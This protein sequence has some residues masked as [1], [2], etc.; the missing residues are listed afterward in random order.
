MD[1]LEGAVDNHTR[2]VEHS[3]Q[4]PQGF[5]PIPDLEFWPGAPARKP[6]PT[7][8]RLRARDKHTAHGRPLIRPFAPLRFRERQHAHTHLAYM[9]SHATQRGRWE[10]KECCV[11]IRSWLCPGQD[12]LK[13]RI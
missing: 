6:Y 1:K 8:Q 2:L 10:H 7:E 13:E 3:P 9:P 4:L 11:C 12:G 5:T